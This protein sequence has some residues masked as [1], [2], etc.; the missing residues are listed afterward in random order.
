M[1]QGL[2][3]EFIKDGGLTLRASGDC[4]VGTFPD[5]AELLIKRRALYLPGD[6]LNRRYLEA[7]ERRRLMILL[8]EA[9]A[10]TK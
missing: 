10:D 7:R 5:G 4:M 1:Q 3:K 2:L 9:I 6:V 8:R